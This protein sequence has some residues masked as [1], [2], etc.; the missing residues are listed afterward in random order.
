MSSSSAGRMGFS[1][2]PPISKSSE[3]RWYIVREI[4]AVGEKRVC[5]VFK[6]RVHPTDPFS[7]R[8]QH[9][10]GQQTPDTRLC[11]YLVQLYLK[12]LRPSFHVFLAG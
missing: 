9:R 8:T 10:P 12:K 6:Q 7:S 2:E 1:A 3:R 4:V 5:P 11:P